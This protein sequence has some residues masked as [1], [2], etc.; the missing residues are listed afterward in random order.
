MA[1]IATTIPYRSHAR[2]WASEK[3]T[4]ACVERIEHRTACRTGPRVTGR[5]AGG[6]GRLRPAVSEEQAQVARE[7]DRNLV[8]I[9]DLSLQTSAGTNQTS[10]ASQELSRLAIDLNE[11]VAR[12]RI[13]AARARQPET[14]R[15]AHQAV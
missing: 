11:L 13:Q 5:P 2:D 14:T 6:P 9:R 15:P 3:G 4:R 12:F 8:N 10:A 7:V 1:E